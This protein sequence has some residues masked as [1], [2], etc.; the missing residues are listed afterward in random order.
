M[1]SI[2]HLEEFWAEIVDEFGIAFHDTPSAVL[3]SRDLPGARWF[4]GATLNYAEHVLAAPGIREHEP[5]VWSISQS[6]PTISLTIG[7]LRRQVSGCCAGLRRLGVRKGDRVAG[8][9]PN[10]SETM[11]AMLATASLGAI[12]SSC[13]PEFGTRAVLDRLA[14]VEP[15]VLLVVD[16][17]RYGD[18]PID[19]TEEVAQIRAG[20]PSVRHTVVVPYLE[21]DPDRVPGAIPWDV[22]IDGGDDAG[23]GAP[24]IGAGFER[25]ARHG[26]ALAVE[27][28]ELEA[29]LGRQFRLPLLD[30][31]RGTDDQYTSSTATGVQLTQDEAGLDGFAEAHLVGEEASPSRKTV[32]GEGRG[33]HLVGMQVHARP[34]QGGDDAV[35]APGGAQRELLG[36]KPGVKARQRRRGHWAVP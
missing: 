22:L 24:G 13:A 34:G 29:E 12:W 30:D 2:D 14:Q 16:G 1:W 28:L 17:Y 35:R 26:H 10:I 33:L 5:A 6:R 32:Q 15:T 3:L 8:Y 19:R 27:N 7:E 31:G 23:L 4:P 36:Q 21:P 9:L 20:L 11:V 18:R 25:P